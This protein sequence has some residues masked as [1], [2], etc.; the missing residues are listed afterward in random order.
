MGPT[1]QKPNE[2]LHLF[3]YPVHTSLEITTKIPPRYS[4]SVRRLQTSSNTIKRASLRRKTVPPTCA[5]S[6]RTKN[7]TSTIRDTSYSHREN[8]QQ[9]FK[10]HY[11]PPS[12]STSSMLYTRFSAPD[13]ALFAKNSTA[14]AVPSAYMRRPHTL[15]RNWN[16]TLHGV[17]TQFKMGG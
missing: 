1:S 3:W 7:S 4:N 6:P 10:R 9:A 2:T 16:S 8:T 11:M 13:A 14:S 15:C 12:R 17:D 5:K